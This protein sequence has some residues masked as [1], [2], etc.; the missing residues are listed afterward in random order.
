VSIKK[1][2]ANLI[3]SIRIV[4]AAALIFIKPMTVT[5]FI[6][7]SICGFSDAIDGFIARKLNITSTFGSKLDSVADLSFYTVMM[8]KLVP[9][10]L[11]KLYPVVWAMIFFILFIRICAYL[12]S[13]F[14]FRKFASMHTIINKI[15]GGGVFAV[16]YMISLLPIIPFNIYSILVCLT[17]FCGS[18][19]ELIYF[20]K[21]TE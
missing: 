3:T 19:Q 11:K 16:P 4:G 6:V 5:F 1:H 14:K 20:L 18:S 12:V 21:K 10:L 9:E 8:I 13:A 2:I 15:T 7:Y 17:A